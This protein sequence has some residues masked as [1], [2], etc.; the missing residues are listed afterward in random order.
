M[1]RERSINKSLERSKSSSPIYPLYIYVCTYSPA[2]ENKRGTNRRAREPKNQLKASRRAF[3][4][5][6]DRTHSAGSMMTQSTC[7]R[8]K[9]AA[10]QEIEKFEN[11]T[12]EG[13]QEGITFLQTIVLMFP[14][15][16]FIE[17]LYARLFES[18]LSIVWLIVL[19]NSARQKEYSV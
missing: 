3:W 5:N 19:S 7:E 12:E 11:E 6:F 2:V 15:M 18:V 10:R 17:R 4:R 16:W 14:S 9:G 8:A 1:I 13:G